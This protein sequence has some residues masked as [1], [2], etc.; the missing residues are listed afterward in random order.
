MPRAAK[1]DL[2]FDSSALFA[3][4]ASS[5]GAGRALLQ[6]AEARVVV[7]T[8]SEQVI[9]ETERALARRATAALPFFRQALRASHVRIIKDPAL[10]EVLV[11]RNLISHDADAPILAAAMQVKTGFLV[12]LNRRH[13]VDDPQVAQRSG[14]RIGMPGDALAWVRKELAGE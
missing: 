12:T 6:L 4:V 10:A 13:F 3:G 5:T 9:A 11:A 2:F 7:I 8:V 1:P 14:L